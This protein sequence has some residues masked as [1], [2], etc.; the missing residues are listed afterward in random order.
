MND[1]DPT[2]PELLALL[3]ADFANPEREVRARVSSRLA[4]SV[5]TLALSSAAAVRTTPNWAAGLR[6]HSLGFV[7]SF[8]LGGAC[9]VGLFAAL[10]R[11]PAPLRV[12]VDRPIAQTAPAASAASAAPAL[13]PVPSMSSQ[14]K[15]VL[16]LAAQASSSAQRGPAGLA[17]QQALLD[18]ARSAFGRNDYPQALR[19]LNAHFL[20]FPKSVLAEEREALEIKTLAASGRVA[21]AKGRAARFAARF[22]QSLFLPSISESMKA[23]P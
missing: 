12:Y 14:P 16:P 11:P 1:S 17:E 19:A 7:A 21:E 10:Q 9:G 3:R 20:R 18:V 22:P 13:A 15:S 4:H 5:G 6:G 8:V 23:I 2:K